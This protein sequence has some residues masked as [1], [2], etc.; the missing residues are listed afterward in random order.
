VWEW[1]LDGYLPGLL[2][3]SSEQDPARELPD[4]E[5]H[6]LRGGGYSQPAIRARVAHRRLARS[7]LNA[8]AMG[9]RPSKR[10]ALAE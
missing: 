1:C 8:G 4:T 3:R 2:L 10:I 5:K 9:L 6:I 7:T